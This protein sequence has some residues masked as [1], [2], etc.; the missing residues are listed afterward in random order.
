MPVVTEKSLHAGGKLVV[1]SICPSWWDAIGNYIVVHGGAQAIVRIAELGREGGISGIMPNPSKYFLW[2]AKMARHRNNRLCI[3]LLDQ[4]MESKYSL[5]V[6]WTD[7]FQISDAL[8]IVVGTI[9]KRTYYNFLLWFCIILSEWLFLTFPD[10]F[11]F[12]LD[13]HIFPYNNYIRYLKFISFRF[14]EKCHLQ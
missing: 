9:Q 6:C 8:C 5:L 12:L 4:K 2:W 3:V 13:T 1:L 14:A 11:I 7:N 10:F